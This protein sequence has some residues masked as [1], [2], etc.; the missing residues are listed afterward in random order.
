MRKGEKSTYFI[1]ILSFLVVFLFS[2]FEVYT[3][4]KYNSKIEKI[5]IHSINYSCNYWADQFFVVNKE[6]KRMIDKDDQAEFQLLCEAGAG[7][8]V[9]AASANLQNDLTNMSV[10]NEN[11]IVYFAYF[12]GR[13]LM[14]T[15]VAYIGYFHDHEMA[16]LRTYLNQPYKGNTAEWQD[17]KLGQNAYFLH[18]YAKNGAYSGCFISCENVLDDIMPEDQKGNAY[19]LNMDGTDFYESSRNE[20]KGTDYFSYSRPVRMINKL[21]CIKMPYDSFADS[22]PY[23][24]AIFISAIVASVLLILLALQ[25]QERSIFRPL[26]KLKYAME[27]F[28]NGNTNVVLDEQRKKNEIEVLYSTFNRMRE[29]IVNLKIDVYAGEIERQQIYTNFL[30][31]QIQPHFYTNILNLIYTLA[32]AGDCRTICKMTKNMVDYFR[33]IL[34]LN[35]NLVSLEAELQC[36]DHYTQVQGIRYQDHFKLQTTCNTDPKTVK[37]PPLLIQTFVENSI[38]H[39]IM[40]VRDLLVQLDIGQ[41]GE[42]LR[43]CVQDNGVGISADII[44][45]LE[46]GEDIEENGKHIGIVNVINRLRVLYHGEAKI[47]INGGKDGSWVEILIPQNGGTEEDKP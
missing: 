35:K 46:N 33:Y 5:Y 36:V 9:D 1:M 45:K 18:L 28:S 41:E 22:A 37:I 32:N 31:V 19:I 42:Y 44:E 43:I 12:P 34:S 10:I 8:S 27:E 6:L 30:R 21:I 17:V 20:I 16:E 14:L 25:Q 26:L 39:N 4:G 13:D 2:L 3:V 15:S 11:Q 23:F 24:I 7:A 29:Q 38:E 40:I 47:K